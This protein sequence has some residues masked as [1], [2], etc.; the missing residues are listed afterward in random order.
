MWASL[1]L[2]GGWV[3]EKVSDVD[4]QSVE[5]MCKKYSNQQR[6]RVNDAPESGSVW[7]THVTKGE[8]AR[9]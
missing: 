9:M 1:V 3:D 2:G 5:C 7:I 4:H 8:V 6:L